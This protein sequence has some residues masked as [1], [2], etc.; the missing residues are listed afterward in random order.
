MKYLTFCFM[1]FYV[2]SF[3]QKI[4]LPPGI[5]LDAENYE[6][7]D[8]DTSQLN[9]FYKY[10]S[11]KEG[12]SEVITILQ[13]GKKYSKF[14]DYNNIK[15]DSLSLLYNKKGKIGEN[16]LNLLFKNYSKIKLQIFKNNDE[17][18]VVYQNSVNGTKYEYFEK[19]PIINWKIHN[20]TKTVL[21]YLCNKATAS[22]RGREYIAWYSPDIPQSNGPSYFGGLPGLIMEI[23][24]KD[25]LIKITA[26]AITKS[27]MIIYK[28]NEKNILMVSREKFRKIQKDYIE[29]PNAF[30]TGKAYNADGTPLT[31]KPQ[32]NTYNPLELE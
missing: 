7:M 18:L 22:Y 23:A 16:E 30:M 24:E 21:G 2:I 20:E 15:T 31:I 1:C 3:S 27:P 14:C 8:L 12:N 29:N 9:V 28:R 11:G 25:N 4:S 5:Q 17:K 13:I 6:S 32:K 26:T 10:Q 19:Q